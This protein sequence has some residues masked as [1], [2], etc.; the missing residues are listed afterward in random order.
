MKKGLHIQWLDFTQE[1]K[2]V[3]LLGVFSLLALSSTADTETS[4]TAL[5][6]G[7][8]Q[9]SVRGGKKG[10]KR[11]SKIIKSR[12]GKGK[13]SAKR[14][15]LNEGKGRKRKGG[16]VKKSSKRKEFNK[17]KRKD[18]KG[19]KKSKNAKGVK[20]KRKTVEKTIKEMIQPLPTANL[21]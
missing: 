18:E 7:V 5:N 16:N 17:G 8:R 9:A 12:K 15:G 2:L 4:L 20:G 14:R 3:F 19:G 6:R 21:S 13:K 11:G 1:M 10:L